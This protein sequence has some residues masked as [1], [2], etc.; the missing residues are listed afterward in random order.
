MRK[1]SDANA[2]QQGTLVWTLFH[3][4][5]NTNKSMCWYTECGRANT[6]TCIRIGTR[7]SAMFKHGGIRA[8]ETGQ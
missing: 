4:G 2:L 6:H 8:L 5:I 1:H 7:T 3:Y